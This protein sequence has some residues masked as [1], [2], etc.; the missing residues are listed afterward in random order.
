MSKKYIIEIEDEP[1]S[2]DGVE[3]WKACR[4]NALVF[5]Q[6]GLDKLKEY[7][8]FT[9]R[10]TEIEYERK[11]AYQRGLDDAWSTAAK[12]FDMACDES[13]WLFPDCKTMN[14]FAEV[15]AYEAVAKLK[16]YE[17]NQETKVG[18]EVV[19]IPD[20]IKAVVTKRW[21]DGFYSLIMEDGRHFHAHR[22][23]GKK[24]GRHFPEIAQVLERMREE[25]E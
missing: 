6:N 7:D 4:F 14:V 11:E 1:V 2:K 19:V 8:P 23:A 16:A 15:P 9:D 13:E 25:Q 17:E 20:G 18:D 12:L 22:D 5:D 3:L 21:P 24:T 10:K